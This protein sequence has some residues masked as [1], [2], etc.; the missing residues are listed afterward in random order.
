MGI[1]L[2]DPLGN[3][4]TIVK[5]ADDPVTVSAFPAAQGLP[6]GANMGVYV[7][8]NTV[9]NAGTVFD[10]S[11]PCGIRD[12]TAS[13]ALCRLLPARSDRRHFVAKAVRQRGSPAQRHL[14]PVHYRQCPR[15]QCA[16]QSLARSWS[17]NF[18]SD[19]STTQTGAGSFGSI[20]G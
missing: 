16:T 20:R 5:N 14:D 10:L 19:I 8:N 7:N 13:C 11:E 1:T 3:V 12:A 18:T 9:N 2:T 4:Y 15:E 6:A 17:L